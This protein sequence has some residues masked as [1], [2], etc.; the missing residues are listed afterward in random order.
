MIGAFGTGDEN[1]GGWIATWIDR[2]DVGAIMIDFWEVGVVSFNCQLPMVHGKF[3][4]GTG[5]RCSNGAATSTA[6]LVSECEI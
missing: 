3:D 6:E 5:Q 4:F 2:R 1:I